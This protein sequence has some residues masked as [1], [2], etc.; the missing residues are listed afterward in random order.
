MTNSI[1][2]DFYQKENFNN[3]L[4]FI[5]KLSKKDC[6]PIN[7]IFTFK[8]DI[9]HTN[10]FYKTGLV[11]KIFFY[12]RSIKEIKILDSTYSH[13]FS[14]G[15]RHCLI[16]GSY[17]N[18]DF[19]LLKFLKNHSPKKVTQ[20]NGIFKPKTNSYLTYKILFFLTKIFHPL[21]RS[22]RL[23]FLL[24]FDK[25]TKQYFWSKYIKKIKQIL[26]FNI[27]QDHFSDSPQK[28]IL[29]VTNSLD[30]GGAERQL[31]MVARSLAEKHNFKV[32]V[33]CVQ[34]LVYPFNFYQKHLKEK[35]ITTYTAGDWKHTQWDF[36]KEDKKFRLLRKFGFAGEEIATL[37]REF[38][39][40]P[41]A[42]IHLWQDHIN[43]IGGSA[44]IISGSKKVILSGRSMSPGSR[45]IFFD[46]SHYN[47]HYLPIYKYILSLK[48]F[49]LT[50][51]STAGAASYKDWLDLRE[52][53][54]SVIKNG[55]EFPSEEE[56]IQI[57]SKSSK[58][59]SFIN[60]AE[61][62]ILI[63]S[64]TR[65]I[66]YKQPLIL[67]DIAKALLNDN[68]NISFLFIGRGPLEKKFDRMI[69][70]NSLLREKV[71]Y[72]PSEIDILPAIASMDIF[73]LTSQIEGLPNVLIESQC[74]GVPP[75]STD[76]GGVSEIIQDNINGLLVEDLGSINQFINKVYK[77]KNNKSI[78]DQISR[79]SY[80]QSR[81][82]FDKEVM[83]K[84]FIEIY[85]KD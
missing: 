53:E 13:K 77:L 79:N 3:L 83:I 48:N 32:I 84:K 34:Q 25:K 65:M 80:A 62:E 66:E 73:L 9:K 69:K 75:I 55:Y 39:K 8:I 46:T 51:N 72:I 14:P 10:K 59:R 31:S 67:L 12:N 1:D 16:I 82:N 45:D 38:N 68:Q 19:F 37:A 20:A 36:F 81:V 22:S 6:L 29:L 41:N 47:P 49:H 60:V 76:V 27:P 17:I 64:V 33:L 7:I 35:N 23:K 52:N 58:Y 44:A 2:E 4:S 42:I 61:D 21:D 30:S 11:N 50:N 70:E 54:I 15:K 63:G 56:M 71:T 24:N 5:K 28:E 85:N 40:F 74:V 18:N 57:K 78:Y 26:D 43:C